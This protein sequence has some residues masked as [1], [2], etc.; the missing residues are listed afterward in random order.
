M[1][2][3]D[4]TLPFLRPLVRALHP[5]ERGFWRGLAW[6][7]F[8]VAL[9]LY[10]RTTTSDARDIVGVLAVWTGASAAVA[11]HKRSFVRLRSRLRGAALRML[12]PLRLSFGV[13]LRGAPPLPE[14]IPRP[15]ALVLAC[16]V[17]LVVGLGFARALFPGH[18]RELLQGLSGVLYLVALAGLWAPLVLASLTAVFGTSARVDGLLARHETPTERRRALTLAAGA[19][20]AATLVLLARLLPPWMPLVVLA[21]AA[22]V[23][24]LLFVPCVWPLR[25][26]YATRDAT[27]TTTGPPTWSRLALWDAGLLIAGLTLFSG[28]ALASGGD[29]WGGS[30]TGA[31]P[32][33]HWLGEVGCLAAAWVLAPYLVSETVQAVVERWHDPARPVPTLVR[34]VDFPAGTEQSAAEGLARVGL[35]VARD[36]DRAAN[37]VAVRWTEGADPLGFIWTRQWPL[38]VQPEHLEAPALADTLR[39]RDVVQRRREI[40]R[41]FERLFKLAA[42]RE[43]E[44][45]EGFWIAPH[46]WFVTRLTRD[47]E[48]D[49]ETA[50]IGPRYR[51]LFSRAA[52]SHM[53]QVLND[54]ELDLIF[55][56]DGVGYRRFRRV[57]HALFEH[58]DV[59]GARRLDNERPFGGLPGLR[60]LIHEFDLEHPFRAKGYPEPDYDDL[61]RARIL[62]V[63]R[64]HG[65]DEPV[66]DVPST[67]TNLPRA[68]LVPA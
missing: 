66:I 42:A 13:D 52:R 6:L 26:V 44:H 27:T 25:L 54:L 12:A 55:V 49:A 35:A 23:N 32:V 15:H 56:A 21:C 48:D 4:R 40:D 16:A 24:A 2:L 67:S 41:R 19:T 33:T 1:T 64:D 34:L 68:P 47:A 31:M 22:L 63:F 45:G 9:E 53:H 51:T 11:L 43:F 10:G 8:L 18:A 38:A 36:S 50:E 17:A 37:T 14:R 62:H 61:G 5:R 20:T 60:V 3:L 28:L 59:F 29:A 57:L 7:V 65:G 46:L 39:R 58:H 30:G